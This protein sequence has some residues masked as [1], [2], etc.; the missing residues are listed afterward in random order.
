[1]DLQSE[2]DKKYISS[3]ELRAKLQI[4]RATLMNAYKR[5]QLPQPV[6][7]M[8]LRGEPQIMLWLREGLDEHIE[9]WMPQIAER[10][11][12]LQAA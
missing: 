7:I 1:M 11:A 8:D 9:K 2:F 6:R 3:T 5:G 12:R 4:S 10:K